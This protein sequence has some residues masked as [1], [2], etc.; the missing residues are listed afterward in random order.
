MWRQVN[1]RVARVF[2]RNGEKLGDHGVEADDKKLQEMLLEYHDSIQ[3]HCQEMRNLIFDMTKV[4]AE[5]LA[6][7]KRMSAFIKDND[8]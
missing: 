3:H 1:G 4:D 6:T 8:I 7:H 2:E 5:I